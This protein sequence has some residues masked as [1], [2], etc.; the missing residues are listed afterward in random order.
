LTTSKGPS[1]IGESLCW[2]LVI[3]IF[4][5][6]KSPTLKAALTNVTRMIPRHS[7]LV[8]C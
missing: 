6:T 2:S 8:F 1:Q 3:C 4:H 5:K 7:L